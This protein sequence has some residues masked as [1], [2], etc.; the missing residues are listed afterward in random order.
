[1]EVGEQPF[2][3]GAKPEK[4]FGR[5]R[6]VVGRQGPGS[7]RFSFSRRDRRENRQ[8]RELGPR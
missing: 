4:R 3:R 7:V 5:G 2:G 8:R 6:Q 1:M